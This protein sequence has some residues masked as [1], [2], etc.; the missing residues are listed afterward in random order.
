MLSIYEIVS[1]RQ[2]AWLNLHQQY[3]FQYAT[4]VAALIT[5]A[6]AVAG[7]MTPQ[8][9]DR[10]WRLPM[11][12]IAGVAAILCAVAI[13]ACDRAY[14]RWLEDV[15]IMSKLEALLRLDRPRPQPVPRH[16]FP[17]DTGVLPER[18][19]SDRADVTRAS[20]FVATRRPKG[21]HRA[22]VLTFEILGLALAFVVGLIVSSVLADTIS[23]IM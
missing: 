6:A 8:S 4:V 1:A 21:A 11:A 2:V 16:A 22:F 14:Q 7:F 20:D 18:W 17:D 23:G 10:A 13:S 19:L 9:G 3:A 5:A 12:A 15:T